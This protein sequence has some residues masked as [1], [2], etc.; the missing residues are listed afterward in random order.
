MLF[1][2]FETT[3]LFKL[4]QR[5]VPLEILVLNLIA[6]QN[7]YDRDAYYKVRTVDLVLAICTLNLC[8]FIWSSSVTG[9]L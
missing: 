1:F 4:F 5:T 2:E 3:S 9:S 7:C 8:H 6:F